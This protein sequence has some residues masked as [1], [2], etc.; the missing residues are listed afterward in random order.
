MVFGVRLLEEIS[1]QPFTDDTDKSV[2]LSFHV[3]VYKHTRVGKEKLCG[4]FSCSMIVIKHV[5]TRASECAFT[6]D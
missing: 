1:Q 5:C 2:Y 3:L 4:V 6:F